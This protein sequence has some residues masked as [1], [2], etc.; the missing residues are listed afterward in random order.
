MKDEYLIAD[1]L[2]QEQKE[3]INKIALAFGVKFID[4]ANEFLKMGK[5]AT[6]SIPTIEDFSKISLVSFRESKTFEISRTNPNTR[7]YN[8]RK[9]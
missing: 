6:E 4:L 5:S 3:S 7:K 2:T 9:F 8:K 1:N